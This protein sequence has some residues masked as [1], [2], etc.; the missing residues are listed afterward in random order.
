MELH[1][2]ILQLGKKR[3]ILAPTALPLPDL[4]SP[5]PLT[6]LLAAIVAQQVQAYEAR[7]TSGPLLQALTSTQLDRAAQQGKVDFGDRLNDQVVDLAQAQNN[8]LQA[9]EDGLYAI[10]ADGQQLTELEAAIDWAAVGCFNFLRLTFL[11]GRR[12]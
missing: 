4:A 1:Y 5:C 3:P 12:Y 6:T 9:F 10:F 7:Q 11:S 2:S 8:A